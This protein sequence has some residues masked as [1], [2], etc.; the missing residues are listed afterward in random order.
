MFVVVLPEC[1]QQLSPHTCVIVSLASS[2]T[3]IE[4]K[5]LPDLGS[6]FQTFQGQRRRLLGERRLLDVGWLRLSSLRI[7]AG[8]WGNPRAAGPSLPVLWRTRPR[9]RYAGHWPTAK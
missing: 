8:R 1:V 5:A 6:L 7:R 9:R 3:S 4:K 2:P